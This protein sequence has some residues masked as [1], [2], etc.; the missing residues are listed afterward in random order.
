VSNRHTL[1]IFEGNIN[2]T[3][4]AHIEK[5]SNILSHTS[6]KVT[7]AISRIT[8]EALPDLT[9]KLLPSTN[10]IILDSKEPV[11]ARYK[12][13]LLSWLKQW[14]LH[15]IQLLRLFIAIRNNKP[16]NTIIMGTTNIPAILLARLFCKRTYVFAGGFSY[17]MNVGPRTLRLVLRT[18]HTYLVEL[19]AV[20]LAQYTIVESK[21]MKRY[22]PD[23][24]TFKQLIINRIIDYGALY[25]DPEFFS[26][27]TPFEEHNEVIGY[28]G[29]L[30]HH[31]ASIE[32]I[33][34][35]RIVARSNLNVRFLLIGSG[36]LWPK[37]RKI[38]CGDY[39]LRDRIMHIKH[40]SHKDLPT[41]SK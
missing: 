33:E 2:I 15:L 16:E 8:Y 36:I 5:I 34:A 26:E 32:L 3:R 10:L 12:Y 24:K 17:M 18:V 20:L 27:C 19:L 35:F 14:I 6:G 4:A 13:S 25:A 40:V 11:I 29:A 22:V 1:V 23:I 37:I 31:R 7:V 9:K 39:E 30:E 21:S 38:V 28:V 41:L